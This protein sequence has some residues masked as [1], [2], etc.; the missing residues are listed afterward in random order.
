M[1]WSGLTHGEMILANAAVEYFETRFEATS[2]KTFEELD[3]RLGWRPSLHF[4][5]SKYITVVAEVSED[6]PYPEIFRL[7]H[8]EILATQRPISVYS[9]CAEE[10]C[11]RQEQQAEVQCLQDHGF[12]LLSVSSTGKVTV[13]FHCIPLIQHIPEEELVEEMRGLPQKIRAEIRDC[14]ERY[15]NDAVSGLEGITALVEALV[16]CAGRRAVSRGWISKTQL[17]TNS[18]GILDN[19]STLNECKNARGAIGGVRG[20][21]SE[22]RNVAH[23][24]PRSKKQ[25]HKRYRDCHNGFREGIR[26]TRTFREAFKNIG[27][28]I[29]C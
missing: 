14:Y 17:G 26:K 24:A 23:H 25:A 27:V 1:S 19:L 7:R 28:S 11:L 3:S 2:I 29:T 16:N 20:Y 12:G 21:M 9:V 15:K 10:T 22:Y 13:R 18:A 8:A 5:R 4:Q 6:T